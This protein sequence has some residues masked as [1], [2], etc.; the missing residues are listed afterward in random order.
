MSRSKQNRGEVLNVDDQPTEPEETDM[1]NDVD[2]RQ[3]RI[4]GLISRLA[5]LTLMLV[6]ALTLIGWQVDSALLKGLLHQGNR[7]MEQG[8]VNPEREVTL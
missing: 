8:I 4:L 1:T 5:S 7:Q 3:V 6:G 2:F